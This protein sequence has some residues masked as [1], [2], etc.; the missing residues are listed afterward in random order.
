MHRAIR[1]QQFTE[2]ITAKMPG[3]GMYVD[4]RLYRHKVIREIHYDDNDD[5][6]GGGG[7]GR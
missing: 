6:G 1:C 7:G 3:S 2:S 5:G 4:T